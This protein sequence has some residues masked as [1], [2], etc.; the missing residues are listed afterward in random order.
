MLWTDTTNSAV[1][2]TLTEAKRRIRYE[3]DA[4]I[5]EI[6]D[7][8][9]GIFSPYFEGSLDT[10]NRVV[11]T[12]SRNSLTPENS[13]YS[14]QHSYFQ[15]Y[16]PN[17]Y[18]N[19][20]GAL[21]PAYLKFLRRLVNLK[22]S[23]FHRQPRYV[24]MVGDQKVEPDSREAQILKKIEYQCR[25]T[26]RLKELDRMTRLCKTAFSVW[27]W[28]N[29]RMNL[30]VYTP[31]LVDVWQDKNDPAS[32]DACFIITQELP[33]PQDTMLS[34]EQRRFAVW[35]RP[36]AGEVTVGD[37]NES[38]EWTMRILDVNGKE[39]D[40]PL[41]ADNVNQYG[42]YPH[43]V[44]HENDPSDCII[45][46]PDDSYRTMQVGT[47]L[48]WSHYLLNAQSSGGVMKL[49]TQRDFGPSDLPIGMN[50]AV[51]LEP[52][53][54]FTF[55]QVRFDAES[56]VQFAQSYVQAFAASEGIHPDAFAID[57]QSFSNA[58]TAVA[59]QMDRMDL[60]E[61]RED[62]EQYWEY[63]AVELSRK[64]VPVW[65]HHNRG[66]KLPDN[67]SLTIEWA[68]SDMPMDPLHQIQAR[69]AAY[70]TGV[71]SPVDDIMESDPTIKTRQEALSKYGRNLGE[72]AIRERELGGMRQTPDTKRTGGQEE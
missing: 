54:D 33:Q 31:D 22:A 28:R 60:Q 51:L 7:Y 32:L 55:E 4:H 10:T 63:K 5:G 37:G 67:L 72:M 65:N 42:E 46:P 40:N 27:A 34:T 36:S 41:F 6:V 47:N 12:S 50:K 66:D 8:Y 69:Q 23:L 44:W 1:A 71:R 29:G 25:M 18:D 58:I 21:F 19:G 2:D 15:R 9:G 11:S 24:W 14:N 13:G 61:E 45:V 59:K 49:K 43:I 52:N 20:N 68:V 57:G 64:L 70:N 38:T 26:T 30:D 39:L 62:S 48:L 3:Y 56:M 53:E 35:E 16:F 17:A